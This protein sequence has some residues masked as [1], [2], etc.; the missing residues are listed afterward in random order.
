M[1]NSQVGAKLL[2]LID[3]LN[4]QLNSLV[5]E[6]ASQD[7]LKE[8]ANILAQITALAVTLRDY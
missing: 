2:E 1:T 7:T 5:L 3:R 8:I 4:E 6:S